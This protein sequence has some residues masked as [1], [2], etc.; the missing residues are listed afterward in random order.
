MKSLLVNDAAEYNAAT[1]RINSALQTLRDEMKSLRHQDVTLMSQFFTMND[2]I[3][4]LSKGQKYNQTSNIPSNNKYVTKPR[5]SISG[6]RRKRMNKYC[7]VIPEERD[8]QSNS[9]SDEESDAGSLTSL[10][11][12]NIYHR[13]RTTSDSD[14]SD[15][16]ESLVGTD[17]EEENL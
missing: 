10:D 2:K 16:S 6:L 14:S 9:S 12:R 8:H 15:S 3:Q 7:D 5:R 17:S 4:S 13:Y 1:D 11:K